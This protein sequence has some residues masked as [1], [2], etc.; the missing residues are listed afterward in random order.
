M[1]KNL[2]KN[3]IAIVFLLFV[4]ILFYSFIVIPTTKKRQER[5]K[6]NTAIY[7]LRLLGEAIRGYSEK[8][9][10]YL[11]VA[12]RW[13]DLLMEYD[14]TL[15]RDTFKHPRIAGIVIAF[16]ENLDGMRLSDVDKSTV[17]LFE[18][19]GGWNLAGEEKLI[20]KESPVL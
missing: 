10:G 3:L 12:E 9:N 19:E 17:L 11:P 16:N 14:K 13:C 8:N 4:A 18:A 15:S 2:V 6:R 1:S 7:N 20:K 5:E